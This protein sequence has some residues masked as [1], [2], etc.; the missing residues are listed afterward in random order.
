MIFYDQKPS[1]ILVDLINE[2]NPDLGIGLRQLENTRLTVP[3]PYPTQR[4]DTVA[5]VVKGFATPGKQQWWVP[6][7][8]DHIDILVI[9]GGG[10]GG[11]VADAGGGG[12][13]GL[14]FIPNFPVRQK[15]FYTLTVGEGGNPGEAGKNSIFD[16]I[17]AIGGGAGSDST[18]LHGGDGG[19]GGGA[20]QLGGNGGVALQPVSKY[21][22]AEYGFGNHGGSN[23]N[24]VGYEG[25]GGGGAGQPAQDSLGVPVTTRAG[26]DGLCKVTPQMGPYDRVYHFCEV[27]G[28]SYGQ[29]IDGEAWFAGGGGG[30]GNN[31]T[32]QES[33]GGKGGGGR[34]GH[35][36]I[37]NNASSGINGT[38]GGG[39]G[40][41]SS[42]QGGRGGNGIVLIAYNNPLT[43]QPG[44]KYDNINT[45]IDVYPLPGQPVKGKATF[46]Y[47]RLDVGKI[48]KHNVIQFDRWTPNNTATISD[49][50]EWL[51]QRFGSRFVPEDFPSTSFPSSSAVRTLSVLPES[52][53]YIGSFQ[54]VYQTGKRSLDQLLDSYTI[55]GVEWDQEHGGIEDTRPL[56]TFIGY[57]TDYSDLTY[58]IED[59]SNGTVV[60]PNTAF[61]LLIERFNLLFETNFDI[62]LSH[63]VTN[64]LQ[65]LRFMRYSLPNSNFDD[66]NSEVFRNALV[67]RGLQTSWFGGN[68]VFHYN[69]R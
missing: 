41:Y 28:T 64:G 63:T 27:F 66:A 38:G 21:Q 36:Q 24:H 1:Q 20:G 34:G 9:A 15:T 61:E 68:L 67:I 62:S 60:G 57:G 54:F 3:K 16:T 13:G 7:G 12:A 23:R 39:G 43:N 56:L 30:G 17:V 14:V 44:Y 65:G 59:I 8:V 55:D 45:I 25:M 18:R 51:N 6:E 58:A 32:W 2:S 52:F 46:Y 35:P 42:G 10:G 4:T 31:A 69:P 40:T 37:N 29:I 5:R 11:D 22:H 47:R 26:G 48:F 19:S 50:C 49:I 53:A 33:K